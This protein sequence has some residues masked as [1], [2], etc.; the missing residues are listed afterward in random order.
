MQTPTPATPLEKGSPIVQFFRLLGPNNEVALCRSYR[1]SRGIELRFGVDGE[2]AFMVE[3][4]T[5][6]CGAM[7]L[8]AQWR[9]RLTESGFVEA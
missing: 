4:V 5:S 7:T 3:E 2:P 6:H 9:A 8:A 1:V